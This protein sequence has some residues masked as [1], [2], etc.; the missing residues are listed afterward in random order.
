M[1]CERT[2]CF[3][4]LPYLSL[5]TDLSPLA[6]FLSKAGEYHYSEPIGEVIYPFFF[7]QV[8]E[9]LPNLV[10]ALGISPPNG[11]LRIAA[12]M[13]MY[14][15]RVAMEAIFCGE[16]GTREKLQGAQQSVFDSECASMSPAARP[17]YL[18]DSIAAPSLSAPQGVPM[19]APMSTSAPI[20]IPI[21]RRPTG[22]NTASTDNLKSTTKR[23]SNAES[24]AAAPDASTSNPCIETETA[25]TVLSPVHGADGAVGGAHVGLDETAVTLK[26]TTG[27]PPSSGAITP[28]QLE[29]NSQAASA[30]SSKWGRRSSGNTGGGSTLRSLVGSLYARSSNSSAVSS[31][32]GNQHSPK[33]RTRKRHNS[34]RS[35][36]D[37]EE[38]EE[39]RQWNQQRKDSAEIAEMLYRINSFSTSEMTSGAQT[40]ASSL[41]SAGGLASSADSNTITNS[42]RRF[43]ADVVGGNRSLA[44]TPVADT[45]GSSGRRMLGGWFS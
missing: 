14:C 9:M 6:R 17:S 34:R 11:I 8:P 45:P 18:A 4:L 33:G 3:V 23:G 27:D 5:S 7:Y 35:C 22:T 38:E 16:C 43:I 36:E 28:F 12:R 2:G 21:T 19:P 1:P 42:R 24:S 15:Y 25:D 40:L 31:Q 20:A 26:D 39:E 37:G 41:T 32:P 29:S 30:E 10:I 44:A 13:A